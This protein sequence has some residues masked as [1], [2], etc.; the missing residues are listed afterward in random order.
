M[1]PEPRV[2]FAG[3]RPIAVDILDYL[4]EEAGVRPVA[5]LLPAPS[6][7]SHD[8][9]LVG[10]CPHL[11]PD[12]V[13]RGRIS[14]GD[15]AIEVLASLDLDFLVSVH[16][17]YLLPVAVL[18]LPRRGSVNLHPALL[19]YNRGWHTAS[20]ALLEGTPLGATLHYMDEGADTGDIVH[21]VPVPVRWDDTAE[22]L[23]PR[24]FD[25]ELQAFR[26]AWPGLV[27]G[28]YPRRPQRADEGTAHG[29]HDL[30]EHG[31]QRL[32]LGES[33]TGE[34]LLRRLRA[35]TTSRPEEACY[36]EVDGRRY[37]VRITITEDRLT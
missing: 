8:V 22:T 6:R 33:V 5:L 10:R 31:G 11:A 15:S 35:F 20:W 36:F 26:D 9:E 37:R 30:A 2:A 29:R 25:A 19:P 24:L 12:R 21:Q 34:E 32:D 4:I 3:D 14:E 7:S 23:Y 13:L 27:T 18:G 17:P 28:V 16:F 1:E